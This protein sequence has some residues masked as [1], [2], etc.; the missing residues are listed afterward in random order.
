MHSP[1]GQGLCTSIYPIY[2]NIQIRQLRPLAGP[3]CIE[4]I[5][6]ELGHVPFNRASPPQCTVEES[7]LKAHSCSHK[8]FDVHGN[9][10]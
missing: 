10:Q 8:A 2:N 5:A 4:C 3:K 6:A 9:T 7:L 1:I